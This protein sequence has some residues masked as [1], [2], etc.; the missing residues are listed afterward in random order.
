MKNTEI[1]YPAGIFKDAK[2]IFT[3]RDEM[4]TA[5]GEKVEIKM[6]EGGALHTAAI[7]YIFTGQ[8]VEVATK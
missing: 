4:Q 5:Y 1:K 6:E 3:K 8:P 2:D 7:I